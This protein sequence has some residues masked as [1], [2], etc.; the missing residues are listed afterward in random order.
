MG[1]QA[2]RGPQAM[3]NFGA[4]SVPCFRGH[5]GAKAWHVGYAMVV[6]VA[7]SP[8]TGIQKDRLDSDDEDQLRNPGRWAVDRGSYGSGM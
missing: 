7:D 5:S 1:A 2:S 4:S 3:S 8:P 6:V